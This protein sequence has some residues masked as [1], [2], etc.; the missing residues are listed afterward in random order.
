MS[1]EGE[2]VKRAG[3]SSVNAPRDA[4]RGDDVQFGVDIDTMPG[5]TTVI[6]HGEL[7]ALSAPIFAAV[8]EAVS[9][10]AVQLVVLDL[11]DVRFC[12]IAA[13][14]AM[15]ELAARQHAADGRVRIVQPTVLDRMLELADL[16]SMFDLDDPR[17]SAGGADGRMTSPGRIASMNRSVRPRTTSPHRLATGT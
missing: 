14:R 3:T 11:S 4:R 17:V 15:T 8:L 1:W 13:L 10:R 6:P 7:D 5:A 9:G 2:M 16:R 12:N